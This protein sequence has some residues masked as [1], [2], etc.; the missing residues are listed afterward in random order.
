[1]LNAHRFAPG[2][3]FSV[4]R[5]GIART[6]LLGVVFLLSDI[7]PPGPPIPV[8]VGA[9]HPHRHR[10]VAARREGIRV[11]DFGSYTPSPE[12]RYVANW[13]ADSN[14]NQRSDFLLV[15]KKDA[16][17]YVF[18]GEARLQG[19]SS[20]LLGAAIGDD[21]VPDIGLLPLSKVRPNQRTTPAG[22]FL[23]EIGHNARGE[24]VVWLDYDAA[25]SMHR[26]LRTNPR[27][28]RLERLASASVLDKR[29]SWGCINVP[30]SFYE[31]TI[32][33]IFLTHRAP[34]YVL[35]EVKPV[36]QVFQSYDVGPA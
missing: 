5:G 10:A 15:D 33:P 12:A 16:T 29:I 18:D 4:Q 17:L 27:E 8:T 24:D 28:R 22:R 7:P 30:V 13:I 9:V 14:D 21:T 26:V 31:N 20:V 34:V 36:E 3:I 25:V 32:R 1:M 35:P 19:R 23:A 6:L 11:A 2:R